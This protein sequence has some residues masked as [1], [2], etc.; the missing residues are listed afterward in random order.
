MIVGLP[1]I[2]TV[3]SGR[4]VG[5]AAIG[6]RLPCLPYPVPLL[7]PKPGLVVAASLGCQFY[8]K[9]HTA[10]KTAGLLGRSAARCRCRVIQL[11]DCSPASFGE[12]G[13]SRAK[14]RNARQEGSPG[15]VSIQ[16]P[17]NTWGAESHRDCDDSESK[18]DLI[19]PPSECRAQRLE[20][21]AERVG[22]QDGVSCHDANECRHENTPPGTIRLRFT[23]QVCRSEC[24]SHSA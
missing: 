15:S 18:S 17:T 4:P 10:A 13:E 22:N 14:D 11:S 12:R 21:H 6:M 16:Q 24:F 7:N 5:I 8:I 19:W 23:S 1:V 3:G 9:R 2:A 20:K